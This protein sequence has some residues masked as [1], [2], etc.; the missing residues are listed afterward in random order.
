[1]YESSQN[2]LDAAIEDVSVSYISTLCFRRADR[3]SLVIGMLIIFFSILPRGGETVDLS[4]VDF[5]KNDYHFAVNPNTAEWYELTALPGV[6]D[7]TAKSI[8]SQSENNRMKSPRD[9]TRIRG[10]GEKRV[11]AFAGYIVFDDAE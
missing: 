2:Q 9:L 10:L 5:P 11:R 3:N 7:K 8:V 1:M 6:G 4:A